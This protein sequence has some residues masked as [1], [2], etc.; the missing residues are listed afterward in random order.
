MVGLLGVFIGALLAGPVNAWTEWRG[1][2]SKSKAAARTL[3]EGL[4]NA[5]MRMSGW[6]EEGRFSNEP[7][8]LP[9]WKDLQEQLAE[10]LTNDTYGKAASAYALVEISEGQRQETI[11]AGQHGLDRQVFSERA[12]ALERVSQELL[13]DMERKFRWLA[14]P[15][16]NALRVVAVLSSV[17]LLVVLVAPRDDLNEVT[18]AKAIQSGMGDRVIVECDPDGADWVCVVHYLLDS[19]RA[20]LLAASTTAGSVTIAT[21]SSGPALTRSPSS[22]SASPSTSASTSTS[23]PTSRPSPTQQSG[24]GPTPPGCRES[25]PSAQVNASSVDGRIELTPF[26]TAET[27][28]HMDRIMSLRGPPKKSW[29]LRLL[30]L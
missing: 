1:R 2:L 24:S 29:L 15:A 9:F 4:R 7:L 14:R 6:A 11:A 20:C 13:W 23:A 25:Q 16:V 5:A 10:F 30:R 8:S 22:A 21:P 17:A 3:A 28:A 18:V 19:R 27:R 12:R 26:S